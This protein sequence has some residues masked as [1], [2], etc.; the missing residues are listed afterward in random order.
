MNV[1]NSG[2]NYL[3]NWLM[4]LILSLPFFGFS[5]ESQPQQTDSTYVQLD[6]GDAVRKLLNKSEKIKKEK[7]G[8]LLLVPVIGSNPATGFVFGV[9]GPVIPPVFADEDRFLP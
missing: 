7:F 2:K 9:G 1:L 5:Q 8:S 4:L 3:S 6:V